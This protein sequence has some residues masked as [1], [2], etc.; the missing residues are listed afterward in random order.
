MKKVIRLTESDL[1]RIVKRVIKE[2]EEYE[3]DFDFNDDN[4][5]CDDDMVMALGF[6][7]GII[8]TIIETMAEQAQKEGLTLRELIDEKGEG[9]MDKVMGF[10][11]KI[12]QIKDGTCGKDELMEIYEE[13]L[14]TIENN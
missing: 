2:R 9:L 13:M 11:E 3:D 12:D 5:S 10:G 6:M 8:K 14:E 7:V 1:T 4:E